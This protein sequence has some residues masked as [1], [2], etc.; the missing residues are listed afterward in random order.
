M[1]YTLF[2]LSVFEVYL[3]AFETILIAKCKGH[4]P[5]MRGIWLAGWMFYA[6]RPF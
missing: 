3:Y 2:Q 5:C 1:I 6:E 4:G